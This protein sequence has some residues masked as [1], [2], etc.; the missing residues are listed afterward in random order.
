MIVMKN[1]VEEID[2]ESETE[3]PPISVK[4]SLPYFFPYDFPFNREEYY[5]AIDWLKKENY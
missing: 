1:H 5:D 3:E 4:G 2:I